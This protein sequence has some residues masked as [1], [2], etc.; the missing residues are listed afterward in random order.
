MH[1]GPKLW[2]LVPDESKCL[3]S[4]ASFKAAI[5]KWTAATRLCCLCRE[6]IFWVDFSLV[7][8]TK[9]NLAIFIFNF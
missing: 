2:E 5:K 8:V 3:D 7:Y 6:Y 1:L 9:K 4:V